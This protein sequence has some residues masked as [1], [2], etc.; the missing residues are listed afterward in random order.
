[1]TEILIAFASITA[2]IGV[3]V[4]VWSIVDTRRRYYEEYNV[5]RKSDASD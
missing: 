5:R 2:T 4:A 1:M 3:G